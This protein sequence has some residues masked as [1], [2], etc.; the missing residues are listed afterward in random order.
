[1]WLD[2]ILRLNLKPALLAALRLFE[3][4]AVFLCK[5]DADSSTNS[6]DKIMEKLLNQ[7]SQ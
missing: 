1:M 7:L 4:G 2:R 6:V 3:S 5:A